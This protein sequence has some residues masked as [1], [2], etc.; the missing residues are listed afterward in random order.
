[1][2]CLREGASACCEA[3]WA[4]SWAQSAH[5][6]SACERDRGMC[7]VVNTTALGVAFLL[8][9]LS[10]EVCIR[11]KCRAL[12]GL[13]TSGV[14]RRQSPTSR[15]SRDIGQRRVLNR[16]AVFKNP[17]RIELP[18]ALLDQGGSCCEV[19]WRFKV[20]EVRGACSRRV[21]WGKR[22]AISGLRVLREGRVFLP[23]LIVWIARGVDLIHLKFK[24]Q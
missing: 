3:W 6:F 18:Q 16:C 8:P 2:L 9:P 4:G 7:H 17:G 23:R 5:R 22:R 24:E 21:E 13:L 19:S 11:A 1:M 15:S 10:I 14:G 12:G 20:L